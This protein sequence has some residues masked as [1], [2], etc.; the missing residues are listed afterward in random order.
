[1]N[2]KILTVIICTFAS[3]CVVKRLLVYVLESHHFLDSKFNPNYVDAT[4]RIS[5]RCTFSL[6]TKIEEKL[7]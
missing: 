2:L 4:L 1:M 7:R 3:T 5:N 6:V